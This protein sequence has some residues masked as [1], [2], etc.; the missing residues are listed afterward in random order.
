MAADFQANRSKWENAEVDSF[1]LAA[2]SWVEDMD[3]YYENRG[4]PVPKEPSWHVVADIFQAA[5]TY[6]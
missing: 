6:E 4:E 5:K 3:G 1:L 2:A